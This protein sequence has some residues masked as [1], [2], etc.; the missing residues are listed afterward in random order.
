MNILYLH[1]FGSK[2]DP[3][4]NKIVQLKTITENV[5]GVDIDWAKPPID[6]ISFIAQYIRENDIELIVGTSMGGW[7]AAVLGNMLGIPFVAINPAIEPNISLLKYV[8]ESVD[9]Y[10]NQYTLTKEIVEEY[11]LMP[12]GGCGLILLD[13]GDEVIDPATTIHKYSK[14]YLIVIFE[15]GNHRF[16]HMEEALPY[17]KKFLNTTGNYGFC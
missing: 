6:T 16:L 2:F 5:F 11:F 1:G 12:F 8:G 13:N 14:E 17:I 4:S 3:T 9:Y 15:G 10:G 7:G